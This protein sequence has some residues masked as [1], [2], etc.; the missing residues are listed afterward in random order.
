MLDIGQFVPDFTLSDAEGRNYTLCDI[1]KDHIVI[2]FF[3]P[4][5]FT[6]GCTAQ[7]CALRD[8]YEDFLSREVKVLGIN[9]DSSRSHRKFSQSY[10]IPFPILIDRENSVRKM[11]NVKN[12]LFFIPG[13]ETFVIE[14]GGK[15]VYQVRALANINAHIEGIDQALETIKEKNF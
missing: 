6:K 11:Y 4:K 12:E 9:N 5:N 2:L 10:Q 3:Y 7:V 13:R 8:R 14:K 15:L 1:N